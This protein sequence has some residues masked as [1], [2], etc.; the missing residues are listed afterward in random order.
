[1][2]KTLQREIKDPK[3]GKINSIVEW[4]DSIWLKMSIPQTH[5]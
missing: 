4:N 5:F 3:N 1:M 2:G